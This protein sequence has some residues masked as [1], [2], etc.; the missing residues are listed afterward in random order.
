MPTPPPKTHNSI[1]EPEGTSGTIYSITIFT[2]IG[3]VIGKQKTI[4]SEMV[5]DVTL[6][7]RVVNR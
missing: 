2:Q 3:K 4:C 1:L 5:C 7:Q 6:T